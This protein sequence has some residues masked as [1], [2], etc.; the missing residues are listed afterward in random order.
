MKAYAI[1]SGGGVKGAALAGCINAAIERGIE[2]EGFGGT[3]AGS[4]VALLASIGYAR[5]ELKRIAIDEMPFDLLLDDRGDLLDKVKLK[6]DVLLRETPWWDLVIA[7]QKI[8]ILWELKGYALNLGLYD[9]KALEE[10]LRKKIRGKFP[11]FQHKSQVTFTELTGVGGKLLKIV[12]TDL[13][14]RRAVTFEAGPVMDWSV[15]TAVR[16]S[17]AYPF[18]FRPV[19]IHDAP[20]VDGGLASNVP[21]FLF[22]TEQQETRYPSF[23]FDVGA[24]A[25]PTRATYNYNQFS[26]DLL[27]A[28][29]EAGDAVLRQSL[30]GIEY[31]EVPVHEFDALDFKIERADLEALYFKGYEATH[32]ALERYKPLQLSKLAGD[33]LKRQLQSRYGP[34]SLFQPILAAIAKECEDVSGAKDIRATVMLPTMRQDNSR[35][36]VYDYNMNDEGDQDLDLGEFVGCSGAAFK[37][38]GLAIADLNETRANPEKWGMNAAQMARVPSKRQAMM[39]VII[40]GWH[41][42]SELATSERL[43]A[44]DPIGVLSIDTTTS[45]IETGWTEHSDPAARLANW[46]KILGGVLSR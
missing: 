19:M 21:V 30:P 16:A 4:I 2:F 42:P 43:K 6:V 17:T 37:V 44:A 22:R 13:K 46:A 24:A 8:K 40:P 26:R 3:S 20:L 1:L 23:A 41:D 45:L 25:Q 10:F 15:I 34:P 27:S 36:V 32:Q 29:L 31:V 33:V 12:A 38:R 18:V 28:A 14:Q 11:Q 9:G 7:A 35:I 39:S 5:D